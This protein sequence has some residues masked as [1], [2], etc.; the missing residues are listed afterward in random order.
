MGSSVGGTDLYDGSQGT[1]RTV[2]VTLPDDGGP[3]YVTL[4]SLIHGVWVANQYLYQA[5]IPQ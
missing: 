5:P 1:R 2:T 3:L 4:S